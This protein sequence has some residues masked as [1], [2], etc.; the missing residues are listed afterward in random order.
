MKKYL[1]I[2]ILMIICVFLMI[3]CGDSSVKNS[4][5]TALLI[6]DIQNFYFPGGKWELADPEKAALNVQKLLKRFREN[7]NLIVHIRHNSE[8]G[9]EIHNLVAPINNEKVISKSTVNSFKDTDL[10]DYLKKHEIKN[11]IICGMM[12]HMCVEAA[13]RAAADL[14]FNCIVIQ[15]ACA[16]KALKFNEQEVSAEN[17]HLS[18][19]STL[20]GSYAKVLNTNQ[21]LIDLSKL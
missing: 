4:E 5:N 20:S 11:I 9:G 18:T 6:I 15:D 2:S 10:Y 1:I 17:V 12:T 13:V 21:Y 19:L 7:K 8:P 3:N 16:T 14:G